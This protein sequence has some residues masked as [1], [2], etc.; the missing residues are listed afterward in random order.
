MIKEI[1]GEALYNQVLREIQ[2]KFLRQS[3]D[4]PHGKNVEMSREI[5]AASWECATNLHQKTGVDSDSEKRLKLI[6]LFTM[7]NGP[8]ESTAEQIVD[9]YI[10]GK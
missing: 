6:R 4:A 5:L 1:L 2:E 7:E 3:P 8:N 10:I 9:N